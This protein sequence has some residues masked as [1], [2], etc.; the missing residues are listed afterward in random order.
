MKKCPTCTRKMEMYYSE[1]CPMCDRPEPV[2]R[3]TLNLLQ[4]IRHLEIKH[5]LDTD[6]IN[7]HKNNMW[8]L[9]CERIRNDVHVSF[10]FKTW[11]EENAGYIDEEYPEY[12]KAFELMKLIVDEYNDK[13]EDLDNVLWEISW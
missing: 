3:E 11:Y 6:P 13:C 2:Y 7:G 1:W 5:N 4:V 9:I 10:G 12:T 8:S